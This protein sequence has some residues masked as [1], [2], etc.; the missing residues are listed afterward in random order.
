MSINYASLHLFQ[1]YH[2]ALE[3]LGYAS[4]LHISASSFNTFRK[5]CRGALSYSETRDL[6]LEAEHYS[7][8]LQANT[9]KVLTHSNPQLKHVERLAIEPLSQEMRDYETL[10]GRRADAY[11]PTSSVASMFS[12]AGYLTE[13]YREGKQLHTSDKPQHLDKR[14]PDLQSLLLSQS[15]QD[16]EITTLALSNDILLSTIQT[17]VQETDTKIR[18]SLDNRAYPF[19]LPYH[20]PFASIETA[21]AVQNTRFEAL[22]HALAPSQTVNSFPVATRAAY[23]NHLSPGL[24]DLL[25]APIPHDEVQQ[26]D[27]LLY[28]FGTADIEQLS[29]VEYFCQRV[30]INKDELNTFL[31]LP[32]LLQSNYVQENINVK[33]PLLQPPQI[34][35]GRYLSA[36]GSEWLGYHNGVISRIAVSAPNEITQRLN[37]LPSVNDSCIKFAALS[38]IED[39]VP[40]TYI[41]IEIDGE[42]LTAGFPDTFQDDQGVRSVPLHD[43][44]RIFEFQVMKS[45]YKLRIGIGD[46]NIYNIGGWYPSSRPTSDNFSVTISPIDAV[47]LIKLSQLVRYSQK[48][49]L[50]PA[51]LDSVIALS[52]GS[53]APAITD[54]TLLLTARALE[55]QQRYALSED[56]ALVLAG[57]DINAYAPA[58]ELSQFDRLFNNPPLNDIAFTINND[59]DTISF[60]PTDT[61]YTHERAVLA[62]A[63]GVDD[64]GLAT[65]AVIVAHNDPAWPRSLANL[66]TL[67]RVGLW[68]RVH[69]LSPP[70]LQLLLQLNGKTEDVRGQIYVIYA[71]YLDAVYSTSEWLAAQQ[72]SVAE[73]N[74]MTTQTY[75]DTMTPEIDSFVRTLYQ[76][77]KGGEVGGT[78]EVASVSSPTAV[79]GEDL[80]AEVLLTRAIHTSDAGVHAQLAVKIIAGSA[81]S[82]DYN[83]SAIQADYLDAGGN[84]LKSQSDIS[85]GSS[86]TLL[87]AM[88]VGTVLVRL[89][90]PTTVDGDT[91]DEQ[92]SI[93]VARQNH[94]GGSQTGIATI[95]PVGTQTTRA[96]SSLPR[97]TVLTPNPLHQLLAPHLAAAFGLDNV[98]SAVAQQVWIEQVAADQGLS[99]TSMSALLDAIIGYCEGDAPSVEESAQL[100]TFSQ[101]LGQLAFIIKREKMS[102]AE[103]NVVVDQPYILASSLLNKLSLSLETMQ[104]LSGLKT[105]LLHVGESASEC[106]TLLKRNQLNA[107]TL[108]RWLNVPES[109]VALAATCVGASEN[110]MNASQAAFALD[111]LDQAATLGVSVQTVKDLLTSQLDQDYSAWQKVAGA[112]QAGVVD[113]VRG[114]MNVAL[115]EA[116]STALCAYFIN[117]VAP[118]LPSS[119]PMQNRDN[120]FRYLLIDNQVS[121]QI[122]TSRIA[123]AISS[124]QLY[125]NRSLQGLE[126]DIDNAQLTEA[127]FVQ[128]QQYNKRYSTWAGVS[129]LAYY[130]EN[131][132]DPSLR[133]NQSGLQRQ[134][135]N[136]LN[137][138]QL[139][140]D[141]VETAYLNYL[142]GFEDIANLKVLCGYHHGAVLDKGM[143]YFVGRS[144]DTPALYY[145]RSLNHEASDGVGGYA[146]SAWT[147]WEEIS[148][149]VSAVNDEVRP[150]LFNNRL[151]IASIIQQMIADGVTPDGEPVKKVQYSLQ[152]TYRKINGNWAPAMSFVLSAIPDALFDDNHNEQPKFN[153]YLSYHPLRNA[154]LF[155]LYDPSLASDYYD[156]IGNE[157]PAYGGFIYNNMQLIMVEDSTDDED[158]DTVNEWAAIYSSFSNNL[159][160]NSAPNKVIRYIS[161]QEYSVNVTPSAAKNTADSDELVVSDIDVVPEVDNRPI[162]AELSYAVQGTIQTKDTSTEPTAIV[163]PG[164]ISDQSGDSFEVIT[165]EVTA[166]R[167]ANGFNYTT[168]VV[169]KTKEDTYKFDSKLDPYVEIGHGSDIGQILYFLTDIKYPDITIT[170]IVNV[171][172]KYVPRYRT[173]KVINLNSGEII[174]SDETTDCKISETIQFS[175]LNPP[176]RDDGLLAYGVIILCGNDTLIPDSSA[177]SLFITNYKPVPTTKELLIEFAGN[178]QN[179]PSGPAATH[180][181]PALQHTIDFS[182]DGSPKT[183]PQYLRITAPSAQEAW[184]EKFTLGY[185]AYDLGRQFTYNWGE[186]DIALPVNDTTNIAEDYH[187]P[188]PSNGLHQTRTLTVKRDGLEVFRQS[189]QIDVTGDV[190]S[191]TNPTDNIQIIEGDNEASYLEKSNAP[192]RIRLN[193]LFARDLVNRA[194]AGLDNVLS[195]ETQQ[196][197]EPALGKGF[198]VDI[199]F[200]PYDPQIHGTKTWFKLYY[201]YFYTN[202]DQYLCFEGELSDTEQV[203]VR[204]FYPYPN[205][206]WVQKTACHLEVEYQSGLQS[207]SYGASM[208]FVYDTEENVATSARGALG[209]DSCEP[210]NSNPTEPM[211]FRGANGL[212]F[213]ELFYYTPMLVAEKLLQSQDFEEAERWLNYVFNP[214]GY[215]EGKYP[216]RKHV[217][218]QWNSRP[219]AEDTA[220][221]DTQTDDTDPDVV[222]QADPMHYK[223]ATFMKLLDILIARGDMAYRLLERDTLAEAKMWY[224]TALQLLGPQ[225][226]L[227]EQGGW[228]DPSLSMAASETTAQQRLMLM[229]RL[230]LGDVHPL[231]VPAEQALGMIAQAEAS[232]EDRPAQRTANSLTALFLPCE[233]GKLNGYWQTLAQRLFNL[234]HNLS[235]D[236]QPLTLPLYAAPADP[237][238]LQNAAAAASAGGTSSLPNVSLSILRFPK[239]LESARELVAQLTRYGNTLSSVLAHKDAEALEVML[240]THAQKLYGFGIQLIEQNLLALDEEQSIVKI[241]LEQQNATM[242]RMGE[243]YD[244]NI[245]QAEKAAISLQTLASTLQY[246]KAGFE[247]GSAGLKSIPN[248]F[249]LAIGGGDFSA[250]MDLGWKALDLQC[251]AGLITADVITTTEAWRRRRE[252]WKAERDAAERQ[253]RIG[254]ARLRNIDIQKQAQQLQKA[255][256]EQQQA[257]TQAHY[258]FL[259]TKFSNKALYSWMQGRL[260]ALYYQFY[261]LSI[262]RCLKAQL[263]YQW[264]TGSSTTFI[265]PGA[266][267]SNHAGLLCGESLMLNLAQ[268]ESAYLEWD[269]RTLEVIRTVSMAQEMGLDSASFNGLVNGVLDG[270]GTMSVP[271]E[272]SESSHSLTLDGEVFR[273]SID[274]K[275]LNIANDYPDSVV[276][277]SRYRLIKQ[278]SV[279]LPAL[280]GPYQDIQAVLGYSVGGGSIHPS[281]MQTTISHGSNDSGQFRLDFNDSKYLPFEGL[282]V[283]GSDNASLTLS[284]PN[285]GDSGKQKVILQSLNDIVLHIC[286]IMRDSPLSSGAPTR[287]G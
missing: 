101:A 280:L 204:I 96:R 14:R 282:P 255:E 213:W 194:R 157:G 112:V 108:A 138:S 71:D 44:C 223:V 38:T 65:L 256:L 51:T 61:T 68:A 110:M 220:W 95:T 3:S 183:E 64:A 250:F 215:L 79:A 228:D 244:E 46:E 224:L 78:F 141:S 192:K 118:V 249:G 276:T 245:S 50:S 161:A 8:Q 114:Q 243:Y 195:W 143:S 145:W 170:Y 219:L 199:V 47:S 185:T 75:S 117:R 21:L 178:K 32:S 10:F 259:T 281:C 153:L 176:C 231:A 35:G 70:A 187:Y 168:N 119:I 218:R 59:N 167:V 146:A 84:I 166:S 120:L 263:G 179:I 217:D 19:D 73:L 88:P 221:D 197:P 57:A 39:G 104:C 147:D 222:A 29:N 62:R 151:Y 13:L 279:S 216:S 53:N 128:W 227:P 18:E 211:D 135:L 113:P 251:N 264:E 5:Q 2:D 91:T 184:T 252:E 103:L 265:Q 124:V 40:S 175:E 48:T 15:N 100:A 238:A 165:N 87:E 202:K 271:S 89:T 247:L 209:V 85:V 150:V 248:I 16:A 152:L 285:A 131:Y 98:D 201:S 206:G 54:D 45:S 174:F 109:E 205:N 107:A 286:Y 214:A 191:D 99:L 198:Y 1:R 260:S 77:V 284:F 144:T 49:G 127:F 74:V 268:M 123:E 66:S 164:D 156:G 7:K 275:S 67:Y 233:N 90:L 159:N 92:L 254:Q 169:I 177:F 148:G 12:P 232:G 171:I 274:L 116:L 43:G 56:D 140:K 235:I 278:V 41:D 172:H 33:V 129:Q 80:V 133:Y 42:K 17:N 142:D 163:T 196:L 242:K 82:T 162:P 272:S 225:P 193:T 27:M 134:L 200:A 186:G 226:D 106:L 94:S 136:E 69:S 97:T 240:Q 253:I 122:T 93:V 60:D 269:A 173:I 125:I 283:D 86:W 34:F 229:E 52:Q 25:L 208:M 190:V 81:T 207:A 246:A 262:A 22:A 20:I 237:K 160:N 36:N 266:W 83:A 111:W 37:I 72:L 158:T 139:N 210:D 30:G 188:I 236:G 212:Y 270:T 6:Y 180:T 4:L 23:T 258:N 76:A 287:N 181:I 261:D 31:S 273:A 132:I 115:D 182:E 234:R 149:K 24:C 189:F 105:L 130:P 239:I 102:A 28:H 257:N 55:Y 155:M 241:E 154:I 58:G 26:N 137:Q 267:D 121:G 63:L 9:R 126:V 11:V 277:R 203:T 230:M